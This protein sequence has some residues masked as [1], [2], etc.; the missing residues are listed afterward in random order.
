MS[1][2]SNTIVDIEA[3]LE[4]ALSVLEKDAHENRVAADLQPSDYSRCNPTSTDEN[5][6]LNRLKKIE[7]R[8]ENMEKLM[9]EQRL[10]TSGAVHQPTSSQLY[11]SLVLEK[12]TKLEAQCNRLEVKF[13]QLCGRLEAQNDRLEAKFYQLCGRLEAQ[14]YRLSA[15]FDHQ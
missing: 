9:T 1:S 2:L 4:A 7:A 6:Q 5:D 3:S 8:L 12:V 13:E 14:S 10:A 11:N 15:K